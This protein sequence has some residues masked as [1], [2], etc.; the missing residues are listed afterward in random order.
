MTDFKIY[1][2]L[3]NQRKIWLA[4]LDV[5]SKL[6]FK[7]FAAQVRAVERVTK[8]QLVLSNGFRVSRKTG[9]V[10]GQE[11]KEIK[12]LLTCSPQFQPGIE[13]DDGRT[14]TRYEERMVAECVREMASFRCRWGAESCS[15][16]RPVR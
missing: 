10:I 15:G 6:V 1:N 12:Q 14:L 8:T 13:F 4:G 5:G 7:G 11:G 16:S 2:A 3:S 9:E